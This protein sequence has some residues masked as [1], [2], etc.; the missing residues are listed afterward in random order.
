MHRISAVPRFDNEKIVH[1]PGVDHPESLAV[2]PHGE[3]YTTGTGCQVYRVDVAATAPS[4]SPPP[5]TAVWARRWMPPATC[6]ARRPASAPWSRSRRTGRSPPTPP[7]RMDVRFSA[8][9]TRHSTAAAP[10]TCPTAATGPAP[11]TAGSTRSS[12]A[13]ARRAC[14]TRARSTLPTPSPWTPTRATC[15]WSR[16][17]A[18]A[19]PAWRSRTT[20]PPAASS[21]CCTCRATCRTASPSTSMDGSGSPATARTPSSCSIWRAAAWSCSPRTGWARRWR[22]PTDVAFAGPERD[23]L[24]AASLDNLVIHRFDGV[25]VRGLQL[26]HP[27]V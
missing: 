11:S 18:P 2:G 1:I 10:C 22:G 6:T 26:N 15:T 13:A 14:G 21:A 3:L 25:G 17:S 5:P 4:S 23:I 19:S 27:A 8:P 9:T 16:P 12:P 7:D 24:V 20:V